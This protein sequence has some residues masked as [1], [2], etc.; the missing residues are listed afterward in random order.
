[1][2]K[3]CSYIVG[4]RC[5]NDA[6]VNIVIWSWS[7]HTVYL[8]QQ[9]EMG[10]EEREIPKQNRSK[11]LNV[12]SDQEIGGAVKAFRAI[13]SKNG[14]WK[15]ILGQNPHKTLTKPSQNQL[16]L[17]VNSTPQMLRVERSAEKSV[18]QNKN[19]AITE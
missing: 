11:T 8:C 18:V 3:A 10:R 7:K 12:I 13:S 9:M 6:S 15:S 19:K 2:E 16:I 1:M 17:L 4:G 14:D 5:R